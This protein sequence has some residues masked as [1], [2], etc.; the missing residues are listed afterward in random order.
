MSEDSEPIIEERNVQSL[1]HKRIVILMAAS[2]VLGAGLSFVFISADY[3]CGVLIGGA[4]SLINFYWLEKSLKRIFEN[5]VR[6]G[7]KPMFMGASYVFRYFVFGLILAIVYLT[8]IVPIIAVL[9]GLAS[10]AFALTIEG[11]IRIFSSFFNNKE[12]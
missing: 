4:L 11:F 9:L 2:S 8:H 3:G 12:I 10:F 6:E 7:E 5:I 1:S